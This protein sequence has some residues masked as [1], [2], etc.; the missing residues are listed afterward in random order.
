MPAHLL[1]QAN[2]VTAKVAN[3]AVIGTS[4]NEKTAIGPLAKPLWIKYKTSLKQVLR[5]APRLLLEGLA[6][7]KGLDSGY[8]ARTTVFSSVDN[9]MTIAQ[10]EVF[11]PVLTIIPYQNEVDAIRIANESK[12]GFSSYIAGDNNSAER[13]A[14]QLNVGMTHINGGTFD[15][16]IPFGSY[17]LSGMGRKHGKQG[18]SE[19]LEAKSVYRTKFELIQKLGFAWYLLAPLAL[20]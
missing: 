6:V 11:S 14:K 1:S 17:K 4:S 13:V 18:L 7:S 3:N 16:G 12:Y 10:E 19:Y 15:L 5:R 8:Y 2:E 9:N 20:L